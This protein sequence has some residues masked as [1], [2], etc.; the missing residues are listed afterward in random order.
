MYMISGDYD[1]NRTTTAKSK[2]HRWKYASRRS[3]FAF[4]WNYHKP[5]A[6]GRHTTNFIFKELQVLDDAYAGF[7][8]FLASKIHIMICKEI[9]RAD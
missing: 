9:E 5:E 6:E 1:I 4:D 3:C 7:T 2:G 8:V